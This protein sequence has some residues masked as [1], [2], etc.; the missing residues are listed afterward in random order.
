MDSIRKQPRRFVNPR[1]FLATPAA[2]AVLVVGASAFAK[3]PSPEHL[4]GYV[5]G[6]AFSDLADLS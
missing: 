1:R 5:D 6:A 4:L 3:P 2:L